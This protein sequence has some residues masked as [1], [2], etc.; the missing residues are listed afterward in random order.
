M[1]ENFMAYPELRHPFEEAL[2]HPQGS[3]TVLYQGKAI[4]LSETGDGDGLLIKPH[5]PP[6]LEIY[7]L[8]RQRLCP[9]FKEPLL[10]S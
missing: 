9:A 6:L 10:S 4:T 2:I 1:A 5:D 3:T 8:N 7:L